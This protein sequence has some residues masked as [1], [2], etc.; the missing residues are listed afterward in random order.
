MFIVFYINRTLNP[1][2]CQCFQN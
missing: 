2:S 1:S